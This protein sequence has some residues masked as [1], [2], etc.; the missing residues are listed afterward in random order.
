[1]G[2]IHMK[3][4]KKIAGVEVVSVNSRTAESGKA[5][6][7]EWG[8]PHSSTSLEESIDRPGVD[9]VILTTP[10]DQHHDQTVLASRMAGHA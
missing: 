8:I 3:A 7:A 1:M 2:A 6:A 4:L 5:F 10:S 9:A